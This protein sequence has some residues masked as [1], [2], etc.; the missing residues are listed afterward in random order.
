LKTENIILS[1]EVD[2]LKEK[3]AHLQITSSAEPSHLVVSQVL[4]ETVE[5]DKCFSNLIFYN[6]PESTALVV[7]ERIEHEKLTTG[8]IL[9]PLGSDVTPN[10]KLLRLGKP[11]TDAP[12]PIKVIL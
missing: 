2:S 11:R 6:L 3:V 7:S 4:Q 8:K 5:H 12:H 9:L 1:K 10:I